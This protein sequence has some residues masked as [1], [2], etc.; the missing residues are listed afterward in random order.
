[1]GW[2]FWKAQTHL[3]GNK[4]ALE[5][6]RLDLIHKGNKSLGGNRRC[7]W[8]VDA[9]A[10]RDHRGIGTQGQGQ[11]KQLGDKDP[12]IKRGNALRIHLCPHRKP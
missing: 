1:M 4:F 10:G 2:K 8:E 6:V 12:P 7:G 3:S 11:G 9:E 5:I